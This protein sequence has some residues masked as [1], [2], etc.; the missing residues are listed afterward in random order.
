ML[1]FSIKYHYIHLR[2]IVQNI[3]VMARK[4]RG[5]VWQ[6]RYKSPKKN[7]IKKCKKNSLFHAIFS[8][9]TKRNCDEATIA[10]KAA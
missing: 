1:T 9:K 2:Y 10:E 7:S 8:M 5:S 3:E 4:R 6:L